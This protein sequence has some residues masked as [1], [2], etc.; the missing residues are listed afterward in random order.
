MYAWQA[1]VVEATPYDESQPPGPKGLP[2]HIEILFGVTDPADREFGTPV[3]Y[4]IPVDGY[5]RLWESSGNDAVTRV[6]D[7]IFKYTVVLPS[8]SPTSSK[9]VALGPDMMPAGSTTPT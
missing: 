5:G 9:F 3:M 4:I 7:E 2:E 6:M 1:V 8:P